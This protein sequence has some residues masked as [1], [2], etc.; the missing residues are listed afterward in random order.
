LSWHSSTLSTIYSVT[1]QM[2]L[3]WTKPLWMFSKWLYIVKNLNRSKKL[4][5]FTLKSLS[6]IF[7]L[8]MKI[9]AIKIQHNIINHWLKLLEWDKLLMFK[10]D[11][12]LEESLQLLLFLLS[13][14]IWF[15]NQKFLQSFRKSLNF[16]SYLYVCWYMGSYI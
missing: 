1:I 16:L 9:R 7:Y 11:I 13:P 6:K 14:L 12:F 4:I 8:N 10:R 3:M 2:T 5:I 15:K